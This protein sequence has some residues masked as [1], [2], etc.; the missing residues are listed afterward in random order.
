M[1]A[2]AEGSSV[3]CG[4]PPGD[5]SH[6]FKVVRHWLAVGKDVGISLT[7]TLKPMLCTPS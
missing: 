6:T 3:C 4:C 7:L 5:Y 1:R 2:C